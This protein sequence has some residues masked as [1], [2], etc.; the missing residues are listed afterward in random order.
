MGHSIPRLFCV[1]P[2]GAARGMPA[3]LATLL[4][5]ACAGKPAQ[6]YGVATPD[7]TAAQ[8]QQQLQK[9]EQS[10]QVDTA[11]TYLDLIA[12]MQQSGQ[13]Y[14]SLA[15]AEAFEQQHGANPQVRLLRAD[16]LRNTGQLQQARQAYTALLTGAGTGMAARAHRGLGLLHASQGQYAQ[17][18]AQLEMARRLNPINADVLS[19]LAYAQMLDGQ[20]ALARLPVLQAAQ[21]APADARVQ[22]NL[23]LYWLASG[24]QAEAAQLLERLSRPSSRNMPAPI[25]QDALSTLQRQLVTVQEAVRARAAANTA[26]TAQVSLPQP[27]PM[28]TAPQAAPPGVAHATAPPLMIEAGGATM[29]L[30]ITRRLPKPAAAAALPAPAS[31]TAPATAAAIQGAASAPSPAPGSPAD[32]PH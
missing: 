29:P 24:Q 5:V 6:G 20:L 30:L 4:L 27:A 19:D 15:H 13:W 26:T 8:A 32:N 2:A 14:A 9:A 11:Q 21:L 31:D 7:N 10:T 1:R 17:A 18:I 16:A 12:Q 3:L 23:A 25:G 22:L 28:H